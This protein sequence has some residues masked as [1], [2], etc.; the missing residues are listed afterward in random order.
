MARI[1]V[2]VPLFLVVVGL[3]V[4]PAGLDWLNVA[5]TSET[6]HVVA[7]AALSTVLFSDAAST[8]VRRLRAVAAQPARLLTIG[9]AG[10]FVLGTAIGVLLFPSLV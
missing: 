6:V 9:L 4:G 1:W 8:D 2:S 3:V 5:I 7:A 10:S